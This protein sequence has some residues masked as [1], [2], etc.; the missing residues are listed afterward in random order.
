MEKKQQLKEF[1]LQVKIERIKKGLNQKQ[2]AEK[3]GC[4]SSAVS[5][6]ERG[7][8]CPSFLVVKKLEQILN[9]KF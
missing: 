6:W 9:V 3:I 4:A 7:Y 1:G 5:G 8:K 2:L